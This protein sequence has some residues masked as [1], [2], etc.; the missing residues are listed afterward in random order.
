MSKIII[1]LFA[2]F[3]ATSCTFYEPEFKGGES[4]KVGKLEGKELQV[5]VGADIY[6]ENGFALKVKPSTLDLYIEDQYMGKVHLDKKVRMKRKSIT[7]VAAPLTLTLAD[8][9]MF[10]VLGL[11]NKDKLKIRLSGQVKAGALFIS[12][13]IDVNEEKTI[14][15]VKS[16]RSKIGL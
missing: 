9:A 6:N 3:L 4:F 7:R 10:K 11:A 2:F 1:L 12:K 5:T 15:G 14:D 16:L 13:K 8:G